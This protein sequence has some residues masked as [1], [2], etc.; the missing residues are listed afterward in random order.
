MA[1]KN[2]SGDFNYI[3]TKRSIERASADAG[4]MMT[5]YNLR[6]L[7]NIIG[8]RPPEGGYFLFYLVILWQISSHR[9]NLSCFGMHS[10]INQLFL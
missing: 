7:M 10:K 4:F 6:R 1:Q 9:E 2:G 8:N 5:H 3:I